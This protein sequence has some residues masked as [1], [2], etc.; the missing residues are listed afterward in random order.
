MHGEQDSSGWG[1]A[2][3]IG[4]RVGWDEMVRWDGRWESSCFSFIHMG[5]GDEDVLYGL[6][7]LVGWIVCM[8]GGVDRGVGSP[9]RRRV[10]RCCDAN[11]SSS[12]VFRAEMSRSGL[13]VGFS[14]GRGEDSS[15][16]KMVGSIARGDWRFWG[17]DR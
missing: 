1:Q 5:M 6:R 3:G 7:W 11:S 2:R 8:C 4:V 14:D 10:Y 17:S 12:A 16:Y 13:F 9:F 15:R